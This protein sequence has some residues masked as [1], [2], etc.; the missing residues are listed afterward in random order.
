MRFILI[1]CL[2]IAE[3]IFGTEPYETLDAI[4]LQRQWRPLKKRESIEASNEES[5]IYHSLTFDPPNIQ[6]SEQQPLHYNANVQSSTSG[7][8]NVVNQQSVR[9]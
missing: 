4:S 6:Q 1:I 7:V 9:I 3:C 5:N 8:A 2:A